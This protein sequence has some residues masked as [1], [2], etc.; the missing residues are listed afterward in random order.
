MLPDNQV[1]LSQEVRD[2]DQWRKDTWT[3]SGL[4]PC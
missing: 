3:F 4:T 2:W 1:R